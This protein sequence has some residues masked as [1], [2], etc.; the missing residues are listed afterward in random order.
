MPQMLHPL[1]AVSLIKRGTVVLVNVNFSSP[2]GL[3]ERW[4]V[5]THIG[6]AQFGRLTR[7]M[8]DDTGGHDF[9]GTTNVVAS[10]RVRRATT[11]ETPS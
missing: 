6:T 7:V 9:A 8:F 5:G 11:R 2:D 4:A 10:C 1:H 3:P